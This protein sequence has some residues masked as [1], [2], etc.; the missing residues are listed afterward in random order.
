MSIKRS[1]NFYKTR[2]FKILTS[3]LSN[4]KNIYKLSHV[5]RNSIQ[6]ILITRPN[7]RLGNQLL[8]SPLIQTLEIEFPKAKIDLLVNGTLSEI[9]YKNYPSVN[10][11]YCL[12]KKPFKNLIS[13][14]KTAFKMILCKYHLGIV[15]EDFSNSSKIFL[16][17]S[18]T[19]FKIYSSL[20]G[21]EVSKHISKKPIDN[22]YSILYNKIDHIIY[23][24]L[25]IKLSTTEI[26]NGH[27]IKLRYFPNSK[28]TIALFT[29]ATGNKIL[30]KQWWSTFCEKLELA[31]PDQNFIEVLP[32]ENTSQ[33]DFKYPSYLSNDIREIASFIENC[34]LFIGADSG[35]MHLATTTNTL[36]F[37]L[38]NG[39]TNAEVYQPYGTNKF[40][41]ETYKIDIEDLISNIKN[42]YFQTNTLRA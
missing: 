13:Y 39:A 12:P 28:E 16:K 20:K 1:L 31:F 29:Y 35:M 17:L 18:R 22:L 19:Q 10:T 26:Q 6:H 27:E 9:I 4:S 23:P 7:H 41:A 36:T 21:F 34:D 2:F 25:N 42:I 30:S 32:K 15:G 33:L 5:S 24:K 8:L 11:I 3:G 40:F 38:F 37:G 14:L